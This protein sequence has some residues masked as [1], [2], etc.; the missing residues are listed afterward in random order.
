MLRSDPT[1]YGREE[2][3]NGKMTEVVIDGRVPYLAER[4]MKVER[5]LTCGLKTVQL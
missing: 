5:K 3:I 1:R 4:L 2:A